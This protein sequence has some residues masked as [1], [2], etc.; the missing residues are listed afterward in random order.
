MKGTSYDLHARALLK[1]VPMPDIGL[2]FLEGILGLAG[3]ALLMVF[4]MTADDCRSSRRMV[5]TAPGPSLIPP[6]NRR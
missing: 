5:R 6:R 1:E 4:A 3:L 2:V